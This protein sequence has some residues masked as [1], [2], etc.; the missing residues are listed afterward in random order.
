MAKL[1]LNKAA[2]NRQK[3]QLAAFE[4]FLP[5]LDLKRRQLL[6]ER[7]KA[8]HALHEEQAVLAAVQQRVARELPMLANYEVD[9]TDLVTLRAVQMG[10]DNIV[11]VRLPL[12]ERADITVQDY[13]LLGKPHW[14]DSVAARLVEALTQQLRIQIAKQRLELL[15]QAVRRITQRVNLFD[16]VLIPKARS[17]IRRI[18]VHLADAERA[19][20]VRAKLAKRK[21]GGAPS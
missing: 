2:L 15:E 5:S 16:K 18:Q 3:T 12:L 13:A 4:R 17:Q 10:E 21:H 14:V 19:A 7:A 8:I 11:G 9:L 6:A 1:A 20:V